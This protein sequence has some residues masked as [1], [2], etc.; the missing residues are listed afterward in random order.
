MQNLKIDHIMIEEKTPLKN[1]TKLGILNIATL[2]LIALFVWTI[3]DYLEENSVRFINII[4]ISILIPIIFYLAKD[5][6]SLYK[7]LKS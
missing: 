1:L 6:F 7:S 2:I 5:I 4:L 3:I